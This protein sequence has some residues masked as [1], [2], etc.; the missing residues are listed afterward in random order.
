MYQDTIKVLITGGGGFLGTRLAR[1][2]LH[3]EH[4]SGRP[5]GELA[6]ADLAPPAP[7]VARDTR[8][9]AYTGPLMGQLDALRRQDFDLVFHLASAVSSECEADFDLGLR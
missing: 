8:V 4:V 3:R 2:L 5:L 6:L 7:D 1:A 9:R